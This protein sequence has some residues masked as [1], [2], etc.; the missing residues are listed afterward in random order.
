MPELITLGE[1]MVLFNP[2][3]IGRLRYASGFVKKFVGAESNVAI[4]V[5]RLGHKSG[6]ISRLGKDEFGKYIQMELVAE[7]VDVSQVELDEKRATGIMFKEF[8]S[9]RETK[10]FYYRLNS[11]ASAMVP[12]MLNKE[13]FKG[14]KILHLTGITAALSENCRATMRKAI[15]IAK[16]NNILVS[17]D[18]NIRLKLWD[19]KTAANEIIKLLD[20]VDIILPGIDEAEI[21]F[22]TTNTEKIIDKFLSMGIK[23]VALKIGK[24]GA[25]VADA[26]ERVYLP[27]HDVTN[28]VDRVG[29]GDA[30]A[31][32]FLTGIL[33]NQSLTNCGKRA[34]IMGAMATTSTDD[35]QSLPNKE[36]LNAILTQEN[37]TIYR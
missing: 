2:Y 13:Y 3:E 6:W 9:S 11:A 29:A 10:V 31:A 24:K 14:A 28:I 37:N 25:I 18:T 35:Y 33:E 20:G 22:G 34:N 23:I 30:F 4:S 27:P 1:S 5:A 16:N 7:G 32:G 26:N 19:K 15:E 12:E 36:E 8:S 21:L 17:F